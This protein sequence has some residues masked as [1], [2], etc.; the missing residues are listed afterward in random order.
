MSTRTVSEHF[1]KASGNYNCAQAILKGFE[2]ECLVTPE[3]IEAFRA[4]GGGRAP[5][6]V[7]G[8]LFAAQQLAPHKATELHADFV[9]QCGSAHCKE[10]KQQLKVSCEKCV[11]TADR[12]LAETLS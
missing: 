11:K 7:C 1:H 4:F 5:L 8:A 2:Q 3:H 6:G 9:K 12:L 10:L